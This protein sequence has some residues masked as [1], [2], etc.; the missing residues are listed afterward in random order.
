MPIFYRGAGVG[1]Y[2][3]L[4]DARLT[5]FTPQAPGIASSIDRLMQHVS[6]GTVSS[7]YIS[8]TRS[9]G[10]AWSYAVV[11]SRTRPTQNNPACV[12][13]IEI[14]DPLPHGFQLIDPVKEVAAAAPPPLAAISYQHDGLPEF[15]LGVMD[16][17]KYKRYRMAPCPQPPPGGG[18]P[19]SPNLT[20]Q[21]ETLVRVLRDAEILAVGNIPEPIYGA[22]WMCGNRN[23]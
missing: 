15:L 13:E 17:K 8:L 20:I 9:Y 4:N 5:G 3:H 14:N 12:Y 11:F 21:L 23:F 7:P 16:P 6:R 1:T 18:T 2:W 10:V 22:V 19:R